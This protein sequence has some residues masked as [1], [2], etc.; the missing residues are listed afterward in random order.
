MNAASTPPIVLEALG[1]C[2]DFLGFRAVNNVNLQIRK[3]SIHALIGPNG[4]GKTT[5]FNL[6]T[7]FIAPTAGRIRLKGE[8]I[9][10]LRPHETAERGMVRSFQISAVFS[11]LTVLE[12]VRVGLQRRT[13]ATGQFWKSERSLA[14]LDDEAMSHLR[15]VGLEDKRHELASELAYGQRRALELATTI[16]LKPE[17]MLLDEPLAGMDHDGVERTQE[18]I[19]QLAEGRT[20]LMVEH[21]MS[22]VSRVCDT[23]TVLARGEVIAEGPYAEISRDRLVREAYLGEA[24]E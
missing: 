14:T 13:G 8:D 9:T 15:S 16:A 4:A 24:Q 10:D 3:G 18:L 19:Q 7:K 5:M 21:N 2:R 23:I 11:H 17:L 20:I 22:V 12:N 6:L 1:L